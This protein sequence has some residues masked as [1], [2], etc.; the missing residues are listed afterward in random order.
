M[1]DYKDYE[2]IDKVLEE[3]EKTNLWHPY[4][5]IEKIRYHISLKELELA[6]EIGQRLWEKEYDDLYIKYYLALLTME[7][8]EF[9][10]AY[11]EAK[12]LLN[13]FS[14][15]YGARKIIYRY[16]FEKGEYKKAKDKLLD[17]LEEWSYDQS[18]IEELKK[19]NDY[20]IKIYKEKMLEEPDNKKIKLELGWSLFQNNLYQECLSILEHLELDDKIYY[21]YYNLLTRTYM[22]MEDYEKAYPCAKIWLEEI[23]KAKDKVKDEENI[24]D[25]D[26]KIVRRL[27]LAYYFIA[28]CY[29]SFAQTKK[30]ESY[31]DKCMEYF[32]LAIETETDV[33]DL[34]RFLLEKAQMYLELGKNELCIDVCDKIIAMD[35]NYFPAY[36]HRQE[37]FYNLKMGKEVID[38]FYR[39]VEIYNGYPRLYILAVNVLIAFERYDEAKS[40]IDRA[41]EAN[42]E[43][44]ELKYQELRL[45]RIL[46]TTD[47]ERKELADK[48][49]KLYDKVQEEKGDLEDTSILLHELALCY[50][51][52]NE[53]ELALKTIEGKL[54]INDSIDSIELKADILYYL[55]RYKDSINVFK[56]IIKREPQY[57]H[58]YYAIGFCYEKLNDDKKALDNFLK[59]LELYPDH[60]YVNNKIMNIYRK[61]YNK[62]FNKE[63]YDLAVKHAERQIELLPNCYYYNEL[64]LIYSDGYELETAIDA[65]KKA[66]EYDEEDMYPY[67]NA[68]WAY[69]VLGNF[70]EA[71]KYYKLALEHRTNDDF[72]THRNLATYYRIMREY[73][74]AIEIYEEIFEKTNNSNFLKNIAYL[75]LRLKN[76]DKAIEYY[77]RKKELDKRYVSQYWLDLGYVYS[78]AGDSDKAIKCYKKGIVQ[79]VIGCEPYRYMGDHILWVLG[80]IKKALK[81][82]KKAYMYFEHYKYDDVCFEDLTECILY[83]YKSLGKEKKAEKYLENTYNYIKKKYKSVE[84][85]LNDPNN[86]KERLYYLASWNYFIGQ[87]EKA[88]HY[89]E[90]MK[91]CLNCERCSLSKCANMYFLEGLFLEEEK[92]YL[93]ALEKY[94]IALEI[95]D[96]DIKFISKVK[97]IR[98]KVGEK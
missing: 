33:A 84:N 96:T 42:L 37:A 22:V 69:K 78:C 88:K 10:K 94:Q 13:K 50:N 80:D 59:A 89:L 52:M 79:D 53:Y 54:K 46:S 55:K 7:L 66:I 8:G 21:E 67:N 56:E 97:E 77:Q 6:S 58:A 31:I 36:V 85:W 23:L 35:S 5:D 12:D 87:Y 14:G 43:S 91:E 39:A 44:N 17:L 76:W 11:I 48:I 51:N 9:E 98:E 34:L 81:Y 60:L 73:E 18:L 2:G 95:D 45:K 68:G 64:G 93:A 20:L 63:Y 92:Y 24:C 90:L 28:K 1:N 82:Y 16:Y 74:K 26:K 25:E 41:K 70:D 57:H 38:D 72:I 32:D 3:L 30:D 86:R 19:V 75:Y 15:H 65:F 83:I 4:L 61:W 47:D 29:Y 27:P 40:V 49:K 71:Y 62:Y